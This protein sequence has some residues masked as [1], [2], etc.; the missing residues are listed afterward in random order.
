[1]FNIL[2]SSILR[3]TLF[4]MEKFLARPVFYGQLAC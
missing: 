3:D 4:V 1:M 2:K